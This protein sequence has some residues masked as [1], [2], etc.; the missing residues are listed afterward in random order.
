M[1]ELERANQAW[2]APCKT[3][4]SSVKARVPPLLSVFGSSRSEKSVV[5][6]EEEP[7]PR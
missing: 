1:E 4:G 3:V 6:N 5:D 2:E 7:L